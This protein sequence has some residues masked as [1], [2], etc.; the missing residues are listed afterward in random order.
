MTVL[1]ALARPMVASIFII[2]GY[3]TFRRPAG[4]RS[5]DPVS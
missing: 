5:A 4:P 1:R 2:Q 3:D